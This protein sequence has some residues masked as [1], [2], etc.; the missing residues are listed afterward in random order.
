MIIFSYEFR[1]LVTTKYTKIVTKWYIPILLEF[2]C[3]T[4]IDTRRSDWDKVT[5]N[6]VALS[7]DILI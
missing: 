5:V 6:F 7:D 2:N 1:V 3:I 4:Q